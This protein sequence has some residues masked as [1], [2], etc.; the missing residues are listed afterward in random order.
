MKILHLVYSGLGGGTSVVFSLIEGNKNKL[1]KNEILFSGPKIYSDTKSK[2]L[3]LNAKFSYIKTIK[4]LS[5]ISYF[6]MFLF[7]FI[8]RS[9]IKFYFYSFII[10]NV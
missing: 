2:A 5:F 6:S 1:I 7:S 3:S 9:A 4:L 10:C 8:M